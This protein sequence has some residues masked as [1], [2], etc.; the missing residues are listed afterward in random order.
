MH[1]HTER[2]NNPDI[3]VLARMGVTEGHC[4][5]V[6]LQWG[7]E[8]KGKIVDLLA[9]DHDV[10]VRYN[11]GANAGHSVQIGDTRYA[12]HLIPSGI[13]YPEKLNV[14]GNGMVIDPEALLS[15]IEGLRER[16]V[17]IE[18][19]LCVSNRAHV[20]M[21]YHKALEGLLEKAISRSK[22]TAGRIGTTG[23]G[24]GPCYAD[25][26]LRWTAIR[27]S[28]LVHPD[29]LSEKLRHIVSVKNT[30]LGALAA[31]CGDPF[32]AFDAFDA[33]ELAGR[34]Q[35]Y[36]R[37]LEDHVCDTSAVLHD[38]RR[39]G[40]RVLMEGA[41][42]TLLDVDHGTYPYV[43]SSSCATLGAP[44]GS[45]LP[46][47]DG[48]HVIGVAKAYTTRVGGGPMPTEL[49]DEIGDRIREAGREYGTTTGRP[50]RCGWLDLVALRY[51]AQLN[52]VTSISL[53]MLDVLAG[54]GKLK[55]CVGYQLR[56][57]DTPRFPCDAEDLSEVTPA[58]EVLDGFREDVSGCRRFEDLPEGACRYIQRIEEHTG[59]PV[60]TVS[61]GPRRDQIIVR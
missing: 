10:V 58:Y 43:T 1:A 49:T 3:S 56:G 60:R 27:V 51:T 5:V 48:E 19:N 24:I 46:K 13:L 17:R 55:V 31:G 14:L 38:A 50:R 34:Y 32:D 41:N 28:D 26:A 11:G 33:D 39:D 57:S 30:V 52:G 9:V 47:L 2:V 15:E 54:L 25:K 29:R 59:V 22:G 18:R 37:Q 6:G 61:V 53:M 23:R 12:M 40:K 4:A 42:A 21:P 45:G 20:V 16:G 36:G 44:V 7:D 8:G 35:A